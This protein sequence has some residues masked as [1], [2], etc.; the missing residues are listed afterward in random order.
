MRRIVL[1]SLLATLIAPIWLASEAQNSA[2]VPVVLISIDGMKPDYVLEADKH[3]LKIPNLRRLVAEGAHASGVTGVLP[4]VTYPSHT[5]MVTG[6]APARHGIIAN[7]PFDPYTKNLN[8]WYWYAE[9]IKVPTLW[10]ACA[11]AGMTTANVDWPVTVGANI[12]F[13]IVEYWRAENAEDRKVI[14]ALSTPGLLAEA[15]SALGPYTDGNDYSITG[16][17]R[18]AAFNVFIL[19]RKKPRF[20]LSYFGSLDEEE[21]KTGP[22]SAQ[23]FAVL[24]KLDEVIGQVRAAAERIGGGRAIICVVSDHGFKLTDKEVNL[25][26]ALREAGLIELNEQGK[27]KSWR[28]FAWYGGG[29]AGIMLR[30]EADNEAR[31]TAADVLNRLGGDVS[32][33]V[34]KVVDRAGA[35]AMGGFPDAAF[36]VALRPGFRLGSKLQGPVASAVRPAGTHGYAPDVA[37]MNSSFFIAGPGIAAGRD[38]GQIDMRDIAPTL[39]ALIGV[40]LP[41]AD[42]R[43]LTLR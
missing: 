10:D 23:T 11:R 24:E 5:T 37:E 34:A 21:H 35:R 29:S 42:G 3:G 36:V 40:G 9:D 43:S 16:D 18:R 30:D 27:V 4:T 32:S 7:S 28:A 38:L 12:T 14:R 26:S 8:G 31:K 1:G 20:H 2:A 17:V 39:A 19:E 15:E 33:G 22:Y 6:V 25:N 41:S 13:N